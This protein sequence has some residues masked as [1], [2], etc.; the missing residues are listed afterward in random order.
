MRYRP[1][2]IRFCLAPAPYPSPG[3]DENGY[4]LRVSVWHFHFRRA[5]VAVIDALTLAATMAPYTGLIGKLKA[6]AAGN[7][8]AA[9]E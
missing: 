3:S 5:S 6:E 4:R 7:F 9:A 1:A 8:Y 2:G